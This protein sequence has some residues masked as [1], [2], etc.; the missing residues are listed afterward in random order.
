MPRR[1]SSARRFA[2]G[3][4]Q[5][6]AEGVAADIVYMDLGMSSM[7]VDTLERGFSYVYDAP[8]DMR[9]DPDQELTAARRGQRVGRAPARARA[10][11][12]RR[13]ALRQADRRAIV[14][15]RRKTPIETTQELVD[16]VIGRDP[17]ARALRRRPPGQA[18]VPSRPDR[19]ER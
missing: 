7:Q 19:R 11:G 14:R 9:M 5:L 2:E 3:L 6:R 13:G 4:E 15:R 16:V 1:A 10:Q 8:L 17:G 12:A 18:H